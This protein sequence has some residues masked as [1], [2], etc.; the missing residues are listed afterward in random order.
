[1]KS[2]PPAKG[3]DVNDGTSKEVGRTKRTLV[4]VDGAISGRPALSTRKEG[5]GRELSWLEDEG[6][7]AERKTHP[8]SR[9]H[10]SWYSRLVRKID[11][12]D[13]I[14]TV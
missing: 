2:S 6:K 11:H 9:S 4:P 1:M 8:N 12:G 13:E 5:G 7:G 3:E 10:P 14:S